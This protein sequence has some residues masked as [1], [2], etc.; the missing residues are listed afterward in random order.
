MSRRSSDAVHLNLSISSALAAATSRLSFFHVVGA[1]GV[2][3]DALV[4]DVVVHVSS[5][6]WRKVDSGRSL[7]VFV[8]RH[9]KSRMLRTKQK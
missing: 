6:W 1:I 3:V 9:F 8:Q 2:C 5:G 4:V 7:G